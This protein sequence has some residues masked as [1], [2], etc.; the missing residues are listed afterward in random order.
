MRNVK[1]KNKAAAGELAAL[2]R[3]EGISLEV[4]ELD[5]TREQIID[6]AVEHIM[7]TAGALDV[8]INN[9][10][11]GSGGPLEATSIENIRALFDINVLGPLRVNRAVLPHMRA[12][13]SG[14]LIHFSSIMGRFVIP[15]TAA[16][17]ASKYALEAFA[18]SYR[19]E[20]STLGIDSVIVEPGAFPTSFGDRIMQADDSRRLA[21]YGEL[22]NMSEKVFAG[23]IALFRQQDAPNPMEVAEA[24]LEIIETPPGRRPL[25][26]IVDRFMRRGPESIN[27]TGLEVQNRIMDSMGLQDFRQVPLA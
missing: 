7:E 15:F 11:V 20:L 23:L 18:E 12:R 14:L 5:V 2:A 4:V 22:A 8:V 16:Y 9:A 3:K 19:Y 6:Q 26:V 10:G 21:E 25:R 24:V 1:G 27:K 17:T 13:G